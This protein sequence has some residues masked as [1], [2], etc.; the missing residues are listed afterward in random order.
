MSRLQHRIGPAFT[1]FVTTKT[2]QGHAILQVPSNAEIVLEFVLKNRD[3]GSYLLHEFVVMP[4]HLHLLMTPADGT[5]LE[6]AMQLI[7]GGSSHE[8]HKRTGGKA[9]LWQ[10]GFHEESIR[11]ILD[12][13]VKA[14]YIHENPVHA[15]LVENAR[16]YPYGSVCGAFRLDAPP[17]RLKICSSAAKAGLGA[18]SGMSELKLR[19]PKQLS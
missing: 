4:N 17:E 13:R 10:A 11:D 14:K 5:S 18:S 3:S 15:R 6:G 16:D 2:W 9:P 7:K 1:Y 8:L 12:F 19:P